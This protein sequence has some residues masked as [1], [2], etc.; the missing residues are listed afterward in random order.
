MKKRYQILYRYMY[1]RRD[2]LV[3]S[4]VRFAG[5]QRIEIT[6]PNNTLCAAWAGI[7]IISVNGHCI[8]LEHRA[9][10]LD[11]KFVLP[12]FPVRDNLTEDDFE[13][14]EETV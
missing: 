14:V 5:G 1:T 13:L 2:N 12:T 7:D 10:S 11:K 9:Y 8:P 4:V 3:L 6:S